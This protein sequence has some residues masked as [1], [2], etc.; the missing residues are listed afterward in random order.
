M[1]TKLENSSGI[2]GRTGGLNPNLSLEQKQ[3][4]LGSTS[5]KLEDQTPTA[6]ENLNNATCDLEIDLE[7]NEEQIGKFEETKASA[8]VENKYNE[9]KEALESVSEKDKLKE[10]FKT[11]RLGYPRFEQDS[12]IFIEDNVLYLDLGITKQEITDF[13]DTLFISEVAVPESISPQEQQISPVENSTEAEEELPAWTEDFA[14]FDKLR[15]ELAKAEATKANFGTETGASIDY[16]KEKYISEKEKIYNLLKRSWLGANNLDEDSIS[17]EQ[18]NNLNSYLFEEMVVREN[19]LYLKA[20]RANREK[21]WKDKAKI[22]AAKVLGNKVIKGYLGLSKWE[23]RGVNFAL[24]AGVGWALGGGAGAWGTVGFLGKKLFSG[25]AGVGAGE[26]VETRAE[27][28]WSEDNENIDIEEVKYSEEY[29]RLS[30]EEKLEQIEKIK[31]KYKEKRIAWS[32]KALEE[33]KEEE[34]EALKNNNE[35]DLEEKANYFS[36]IEKKYEK[37]KSR[38]AMKK[39][40]IVTVAGAGTGMFANL[41]EGV[42]ANVPE[43]VGS[44]V[45]PNVV[46]ENKASSSLEHQELFRGPRVGFKPSVTE[47]TGVKVEAEHITLKPKMGHIPK[48]V[49]ETQTPENPTVSEPEP[50]EVSTKPTQTETSNTAESIVSEK[51]EFVEPKL[52][53]EDHPFVGPI[54]PKE[55][56]FVGPMLPKEEGFVGPKLPQEE[57]VNT[58]TVEKIF[59]NPENLKHIKIEGKTNSFWNV[60]QKG[61]EE[62]EQFRGFTEAQKNNAISYF[63]NKG[64]GREIG[65]PEKYGLT[66]D[67]DFGVKVETGKEIDLSKLLGDAEE[68][69]KVL[70][71]A[72]KK[73]LEEQQNILHKDA[74]IATYLQENPNVK[75]TNDKVAEILATKP[76]VEAINEIPE[77]SESEAPVEPSPILKTPTEVEPIKSNIPE[78]LENPVIVEPIKSGISDN[79]ETNSDSDSLS[80]NSTWAI[81]V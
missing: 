62:N 31:R 36:E 23:R 34:I 70:D 9:I 26:F 60:V 78:T 6:W 29:S 27:K 19:D 61:L 30:S 69:K 18:K 12:K 67:P 73:T 28:R 22:E 32:I 59:E 75:L 68:V 57:I 48:P 64:I 37:K 40:G 16:L 43:V 25:V 20:I 10:K 3:A 47:N 80:F 52:P 50:L 72:A 54:E 58:A 55:S 42:F 35:I 5:E 45:E 14:E 66:S 76:K 7:I 41:V 79:L 13:L 51:Q 33:A 63:T 4:L 71:G 1:E 8:E 17:E 2:E 15:D 77:P 53:Q 44:N 81:A 56:D 74:Q 46:I 21:T 38:M 49:V 39:M 65:D 11:I 24:G